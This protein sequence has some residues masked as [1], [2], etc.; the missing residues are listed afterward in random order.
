ML[1]N[2]TESESKQ[3]TNLVNQIVC[4]N[5]LPEI[6]NNNDKY[7]G[8]HKCPNCGIRHGQINDHLNHIDFCNGIS[9]D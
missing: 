3:P 4:V 9:L 6:K 8:Y 1:R 5:D 2:K 7:E